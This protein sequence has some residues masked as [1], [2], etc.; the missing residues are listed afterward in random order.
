[1][2]SSGRQACVRACGNFGTVLK[3]GALFYARHILSTTM[4]S[5]ASCERVSNVLHSTQPPLLPITIVP[6]E[7]PG[8]PMSARAKYGTSLSCSWK[9]G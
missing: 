8:L 7:G 4:K 5:P 9:A 3:D 2:R 1:M 6:E